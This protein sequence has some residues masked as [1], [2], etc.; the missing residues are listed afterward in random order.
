MITKKITTILTVVALAIAGQLSA[1]ETAAPPP[2]VIV[3]FVDDQGYE[4]LGCFG[5][6]KIKTPNIDRMAKEGMRFTDFYSAN[7]VCSPSRAAL[8]TGC[9]PTRIGIPGVLFP[10]HDVGLNPEETTI[11]DMLKAKGYA[12]QCVGKWHIGHKPEFLPTRQGFDAYYGIPYSNDMSLDRAAKLA[13]DIIFREGLSRENLKTKKDWVPLMRNEEVIEYPVDQST[14]TQRY[15]TEAVSFIKANKDKPFFLYLAQTMP[16]IPL[17]ASPAFKGKSARGPYGDTIEEIDWSVGEVLKTLKAEGLD[18][19]TIVIYTSDNGPWDLSGGRGGSAFPLRGHKFTTFEGGQRVPCVMRWPGRIPAGATC[20]E[21]ASTIDIFPTMAHLTG[22][23]LPEKKIDGKN[24]FP[25]MSGEAGA[26]SPYDYFYFYKGN[27]LESARSGKWKL[28]MI[29]GKPFL[30][31]LEEDIGEKQSK[32]GAFPEVVGR[33]Q[34]AMADFDAELKR[35]AR[36]AGR[37][38]SQA[39]PKKNGKT[40]KVAAKLD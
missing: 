34:K 6:P 33:I 4:D 27:N 3:I 36:P 21:I 39:A 13:D 7:S 30:Y 37:I 5:S 25:L 10:R 19:N 16:H 26:K 12:T 23:A 28:R 40:K 2:N 14:I 11:A 17:F 15:T 22:S 32:A 31:N 20:S 38:S 1:A 35:Q 18:E 8:L 9:Y 24:I 29:K